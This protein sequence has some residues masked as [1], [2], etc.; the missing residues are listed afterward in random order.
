MCTALMGERVVLWK[1][2]KILVSLGR[3]PS[4]KLG[5]ESGM[6][7]QLVVSSLP[8]NVVPQPLRDTSSMCSG[9]SG[10]TMLPWTQT[11][12][13]GVMALPAE[14]LLESFI[15]SYFSIFPR[16]GEGEACAS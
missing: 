9:Y 11:V 15:W 16:A 3:P 8:Q 10:F 13:L 5:T 7:N 4:R 12:C 14:G 1:N 6:W 2:R